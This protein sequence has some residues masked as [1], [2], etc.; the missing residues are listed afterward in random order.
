[1]DYPFPL[2]KWQQSPLEWDIEQLESQIA[3]SRMLS[4]MDYGSPVAIALRE[5]GGAYHAGYKRWQM[6]YQQSKELEVINLQQLQK[7][8]RIYLQQL[9]AIKIISIE[10]AGVVLRA[11]QLDS[12]V[13]HELIDND[14]EDERM[15]ASFFSRIGDDSCPVDVGRPPSLIELVHKSI[16]NHYPQK[17]AK[18]VRM[19]PESLIYAV[20]AMKYSGLGLYWLCR[21]SIPPTTLALPGIGDDSEQECRDFAFLLLSDAKVAITKMRFL[22]AHERSKINRKLP[23][24]YVS[25]LFDELG[26]QI[27]DNGRANELIKKKSDSAKK[28]RSRGVDKD[29]VM[30]AIK[31]GTAKKTIAIEFGISEARVSQINK[32]NQSK[33]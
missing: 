25:T 14:L 16:S 4:C 7:I 6:F 2:P 33:S 10:L 5:L 23:E 13:C 20:M 32:M 19:L 17:I 3:D 29:A 24:K 18:L 9:E 27:Q 31:A 15:F 26:I 8:E 21:A 1:M 11:Q 12:L 30:N 28:P 22:E